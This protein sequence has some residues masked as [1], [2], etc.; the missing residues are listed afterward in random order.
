MDHKNLLKSVISYK[1]VLPVMDK[2]IEVF[3]GYRFKDSNS[4][5]PAI[6]GFELLDGELCQPFPSG[7]GYS[8]AVRIDSKIPPASAV[9]RKLDEVI[10]RI[11]LDE[12]I[13]KIG[14]TRKKQIKEDIEQDI[15]FRMP[16]TSK[17]IY[18]IYHVEQETLLI[19]NASKGNADLITSLL[20]QAL[21]SI[22]AT[23]I[24]ISGISDGLTNRLK[25]WLDGNNLAFGSDISVGDTCVLKGT[26]KEK[27]SVSGEELRKYNDLREGLA[28]FM[29]CESLSLS[30][31]CDE[32]GIGFTLTKDFNI[33]G[34]QHQPAKEDFEDEDIVYEG[35]VE[36]EVRTLTVLSIIDALTK[37]FDNDSNDKNG[38][39]NEQSQ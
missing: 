24:Y 8:F 1:A 7:K 9:N 4:I 38:E 36:C 13:N 28:N 30:L 5:T 20:V 22:K 6:L 26:N 11:K 37:I 19:S 39:N 15:R 23:T 18:C 34:I 14:R 29:T 31:A 2:A 3:S 32:E 16:A 10:E 17:T 33:K 27:I 35:R 12:G 25:W 21:G